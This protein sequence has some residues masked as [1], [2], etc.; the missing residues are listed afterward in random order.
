MTRFISGSC[1]QAA[2]SPGQWTVPP[3]PGSC[4]GSGQSCG[5]NRPNYWW[6]CS[7][8]ALP[9]H[10]SSRGQFRACGPWCSAR[11]PRRTAPGY[12][13]A[14]TCS[15]SLPRRLQHRCASTVPAPRSA[16][17]P[18][19]S[20]QRCWLRCGPRTPVPARAERAPVPAGGHGPA[21]AYGFAVAHRLP[22][23]D[24]AARPGNPA[25]AAAAGAAIEPLEA[26]LLDHRNRRRSGS[27]H[28]R[29]HP[30]PRPCRPV[31]PRDGGR[32]LRADGPVASAVGDA[33][34]AG[35]PGR[36]TAIM[37]K[38]HHT[39]GGS[40]AI[41]AALTQLFDSPP[42]T[43]VPRRPARRSHG[44]GLAIGAMTWGKSLSV[45]GRSPLTGP[46]G[47]PGT[48]DRSA[49]SPESLP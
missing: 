47:K 9:P 5:R 40:Q 8:R 21:T 25:A 13:M 2:G 11:T 19:R 20:G 48:A 15:S 1:G 37:V 23:R 30:G 14:S 38:V 6:P 33:A 24:H 42:P 43:S 46:D 18:H 10:R 35:L 4:P 22:G 49:F 31:A 29:G 27:A 32:L 36:Q 7:P 17:F 44:V 16:S 39:L 45:P 28:R 12:P 34:G 41:I 26:S 3:G